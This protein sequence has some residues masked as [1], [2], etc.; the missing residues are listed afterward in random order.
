MILE[1][2][3]ARRK[4]GA[5]KLHFKSEDYTLLS[6]NSLT[7]DD[8]TQPK[9]YDNNKVWILPRR[10]LYQDPSALASLLWIGMIVLIGYGIWL[11]LSGEDTK[12]L[13]DYDEEDDAFGL[14]N[15]TEN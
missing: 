8:T 5:S 14:I 15:R 1:T 4:E 7:G 6:R 2:R 12:L 13:D 10:D 11:L 9:K 3:R